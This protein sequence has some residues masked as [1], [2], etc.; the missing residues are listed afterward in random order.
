MNLVS[1]FQII[2]LLNVFTP[3]KSLE[4]FQDL[5]V[6]SVFAFLLTLCLKL[7]F[8]GLGAVLVHWSSVLLLTLIVLLMLRPQYC[9]NAACDNYSF[10]IEMMLLN[11]N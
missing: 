5:Y 10:R 3:Q 1:L 4:E 11:H 6:S 8:Y 9:P 7:R 2:R